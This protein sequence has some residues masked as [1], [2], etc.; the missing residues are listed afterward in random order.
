MGRYENFGFPEGEFAPIH[1]CFLR[2]STA[3]V[4]KNS[5]ISVVRTV[6]A[7]TTAQM[8]PNRAVSAH[9]FLSAAKGGTT[10][11][12]DSGNGIFAAAAGCS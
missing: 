7:N 9:S 4:A 11:C 12:H 2:A 3:G 10:A 8:I 5:D 1:S 6:L